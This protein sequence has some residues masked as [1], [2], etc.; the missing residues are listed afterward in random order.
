MIGSTRPGRVGL[1]VAQW[2]YERATAYGSWD[3]EIA[4]LAEIN[5]PFMDEPSHPRLH[6]YTH[7]HTKAWS[8]RVAAADALLFVTPEYN[9][10]FSA[11][12]K[13]ALDYLF[14]EWQYKPVAFVSYGGA[15]GGVRAVQMLKQVVTT[16]KM[17]PLY[18]SVQIPFV[19][20]YFDE[21][22]A[23]HPSEAAE[24][25]AHDMLAELAR[26]TKA[27]QPLRAGSG[28]SES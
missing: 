17:V 4:D 25:A 15:S 19:Q 27:L 7:A 21:S 6:Q 8:E 14:N 16:L 5:L 3:V 28:A 18:E 26:W 20:Q 13:N 12:L 9:F 11:P 1:P 10:G 24:Q 23:F 22:R 2:I